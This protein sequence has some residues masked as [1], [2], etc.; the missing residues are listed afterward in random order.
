MLRAYA[1]SGGKRLI[2]VALTTS[3]LGLVGYVM[4]VVSNELSC[5]FPSRISL[6]LYL[7][8]LESSNSVVHHQAKQW[9]LRHVEPTYRWFSPNCRCLSTRGKCKAL[10]AVSG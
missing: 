3:F 5:P 10:P 7:M 1:F 9:L 2:L 6:D 4:W 8:S